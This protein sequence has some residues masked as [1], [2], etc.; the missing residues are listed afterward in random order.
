VDKYGR[1]V[2]PY[3]ETRDYVMK[4]GSAAATSGEQPNPESRTP[5]SESRLS[6][7]ESRTGAPAARVVGG[8]VAIPNPGKRVMYKTIEIVNG[9]PIP[10]Y[11]TERPSSGAYDIIN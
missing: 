4:V 6:N 8:G 7:P 5:N 9:Q 1:A 2:P 10:R 3:R 11:T